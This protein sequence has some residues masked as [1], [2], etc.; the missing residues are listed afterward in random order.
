MHPTLTLPLQAGRCYVRRDGTITPPLTVEDPFVVDPETNYVFAPHAP[1]VF[2][3]SPA[4][5][6]DKDLVADFAEHWTRDG[7]P[8]RILA[9]DLDNPNYTVVAA[10]RGL[11]GSEFPYTFTTEGYYLGEHELDRRDIVTMIP[12]LK[13]KVGSVYEDEIGNVYD[14]VYHDTRRNLFVGF[15]RHNAT[16]S[17]DPLGEATDEPIQLVKEITE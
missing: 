15:G 10:I 3:P 16:F 6:D 17:F 13:L 5:F 2:G 14:I 4:V 7:R 1:D 12:P 11:D 9:T 8:V